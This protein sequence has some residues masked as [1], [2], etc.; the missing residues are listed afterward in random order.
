VSDQLSFEGGPLTLLLSPQFSE[1]LDKSVSSLFCRRSL[2]RLNRS[3]T[4]QPHR[5][6]R[7]HRCRRCPP[8][9]HLALVHLARLLRPPRRSRYPRT[10]LPA[11]ASRLAVFKRS[12]GCEDVGKTSVS[13]RFSFLFLPSKPPIIHPPSPL[14]SSFLGWFG[15]IGIG[16]LYYALEAEVS[17][18]TLASEIYSITS[19]LIFA[20]IFV[21]GLTIRESIFLPLLTYF[22]S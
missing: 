14:R 16:A 6:L 19:F 15:P 22:S 7:L 8:L 21:H 13:P 11:S 3:A 9:R 20:S 10:P 12:S 18:D 1:G 17:S 5:H 4:F 2:S